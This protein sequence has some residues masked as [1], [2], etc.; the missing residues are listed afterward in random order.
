MVLMFSIFSGHLINHYDHLFMCG[1][2][3][4]KFNSWCGNEL[5]RLS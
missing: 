5:I 2:V 4:L 1:Q 3:L